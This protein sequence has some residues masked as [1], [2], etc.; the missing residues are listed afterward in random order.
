MEFLSYHACLFWS[1]S[2]W[3]SFTGRRF[4][5]L[6]NSY[7]KHSWIIWLLRQ[8]QHHVWI[9]GRAQAPMV[10]RKIRHLNCI[11][12][13][14]AAEPHVVEAAD[15]LTVSAFRVCLTEFSSSWVKLQPEWVRVQRAEHIGPRG[16]LQWTICTHISLLGRWG[17]LGSLLGVDP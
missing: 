16:Q 17:F 8:K 6:V 7:R 9:P 15:G 14:L 1:A 4:C 2:Q 5:I 10:D 11:K 13:G 12:E 3:F